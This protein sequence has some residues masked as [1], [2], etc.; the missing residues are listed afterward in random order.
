MLSYC[1]PG[2]DDGP[3]QEE[4]RGVGSVFGASEWHGDEE[5]WWCAPLRVT[6]GGEGG[7]EEGPMRAG[8][9]V[10]GM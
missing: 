5:P 1:H 9:M 2:L 7:A 3:F 4:G 8:K 6:V 10:E